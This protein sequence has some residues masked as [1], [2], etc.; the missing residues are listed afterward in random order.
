MNLR[1][2]RYFV[3]VVDAG[4]LTAAAAAIPIA[5]PA[6]TRQMRELEADLGVQLLQR[7]PRGIRL[8]PAGVTLYEYAERVLADTTRLRDKLAHARQ[9]IA[10]VVV[11]VPPTLAGLFLP[12]LVETC[13]TKIDGIELQTKE[14]FTPQLM[15]W[16]ERGMID[17]AILTNLDS[18]QRLSLRPLLIEPFALFSHVDMGL[19]PV[20]MVNQL[21]RI[22]LLMTT[23]H[24]RLVEQQLLELGKR[25][26]VYAQIDS[27]DA[28]RG[29][30]MRGKWATVMPVSVF[31][32]LPAGM[33][34]RMSEISGAQLHRQLVLASHLEPRQPSALLLIHELIYA[35]LGRL[36]KLGTFS[37]GT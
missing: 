3:A 13:A 26:N 21:A 22:P 23:L 32:H 30:V 2:L 20:V 16:L 4:S 1:T 5:Q 35:E 9:D 31:K 14:A 17:T 25:L 36:T 29:L 34:L 37:F 7:L 8:T 6:L 19:G 11:G 15:D 24:R 10:T 27:V 18:G 12:G 28:I 33:P